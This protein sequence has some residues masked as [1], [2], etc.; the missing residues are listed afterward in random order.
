MSS[1]RQAFLDGAGADN[2]CPRMLDVSPIGKESVAG[3]WKVCALFHEV[4]QGGDAVMPGAS[5]S[6]YRAGIRCILAGGAD[7][8]A[9]QFGR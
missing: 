3:K 8:G 6:S 9:E 7:G 1:G 5:V 2:L 4:R